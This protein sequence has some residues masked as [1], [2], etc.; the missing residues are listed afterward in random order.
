MLGVYYMNGE[1]GVEVDL[2][3][4]RRWTARAAAKGHEHAVK[5]LAM[6]DAGPLL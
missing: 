2:E 3:E 1:G 5:K 4:A 6:M